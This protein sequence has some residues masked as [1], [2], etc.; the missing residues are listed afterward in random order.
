MRRITI[1]QD[2]DNREKE[3]VQTEVGKIPRAGKSQKQDIMKTRGSSMKLKK[4]SEP[5]LFV[6]SSGKL[7]SH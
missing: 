1:E 7:R 6:K 4:L 5:S 3:K 2:R